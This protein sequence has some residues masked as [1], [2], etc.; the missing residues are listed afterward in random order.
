MKLDLDWFD[1]GVSEEDDFDVAGLL[2][3]EDGLEDELA[4][5]G[6]RYLEDLK[7][8]LEVDDDF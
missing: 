4:I 2:P 6:D 1:G 8:E 7:S 3:H 5:A